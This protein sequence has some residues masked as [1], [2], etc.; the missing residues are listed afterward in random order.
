[1]ITESYEHEKIADLKAQA[2]KDAA[3]IKLLESE[4]ERLVKMFADD[5][6]IESAVMEPE[7]YNINL[8]GKGAMLLIGQIITIFRESGGKNF[9]TN[10]LEMELPDSKTREIFELTIQKVDGEDSPAQ[11]I[12]RQ[13]AKIAELEA[14]IGPVER[15]AIE[16]AIQNALGT[17]GWTDMHIRKRYAAIL[18]D[19]LDP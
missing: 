9:L 14:R 2:T 17:A 8:R 1:M 13:A 7:Y 19:I 10:T 3:R 11:K 15:E 18:R 4:N 12:Q 5:V 6:Y 16:W